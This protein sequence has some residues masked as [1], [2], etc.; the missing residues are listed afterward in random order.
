MQTP[1]V[2]KEGDRR[3]AGVIAAV[4]VLFV[5]TVGLV[6]VAAV[7]H[8]G[9]DQA[10]SDE[11]RQWPEVAPA[12]SGEELN[13]EPSDVW[14][15]NG[16]TLFNQR[17]SPL[18]H[19]DTSNV[20]DLKGVWMTDLGSATAAKYSAE[21]QP[22]VYNG[23]IYV[24]TGDDDVFAVD[25]ETGRMR[26]KY[27]AGIDQKI[28][29]VCCGWLSRGV[30]LGQGKV[31]I[32]QLD[33]MLVAL[34]QQTG[35]AAWKTE[36]GSWRDGY[37][38]TAAPLYYD[39]MVITGVSG[40]EFSIRGSVQAYDAGDRRARVA[41]L[42]RSGPR[43]GGA[44][45][46]AGGQRGVDARRRT[47]VA[48]ACG[49]SRARPPVLL[50]GQRVAGSRRRRACRRQPLCGLDRCARREDGRLPLALSRGA[51]R[52]LGLRRAEPG[53]PLRRSDRRPGAQGARADQQ[54]RLDV[55]RRPANRRADPADQGGAR[56][57]GRAAEDIGDSADPAVRPVLPARGDRCGRGRDLQ[58]GTGD[59]ERSDG[60][61]DR[62]GRDLCAV[63]PGDTGDH[64]RPARRDEL[65]ADE[66][67]PQDRD[68]LHLCDAL[69]FRVHAQR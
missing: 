52:H 26:W 37:T 60:A 53:R 24:P 62:Q 47:D 2:P 19:I 68:A 32:G 33:G 36:V 44:R 17:Y 63:P 45:Q 10:A 16:G 54:D 49:R 51:P 31:F 25:L 48:D 14:L 1:D 3:L 18:D 6:T 20:K 61:S 35:K 55:R 66:L 29:T 9:D 67:Q 5:A 40:G 15:T 28:T 21:G 59:R 34:D 23:V 7:A 43:R 56:P 30:A 39:G 50:H 38:I 58:A 13:A 42:H 4:V 41:V 27:E 8:Q 11:G 46:L 69:G 22:I 65:A 12:F 64:P 57:A